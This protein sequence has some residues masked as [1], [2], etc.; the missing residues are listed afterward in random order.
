MK[1][2]LIQIFLVIII[3]LFIPISLAY[4][5][6]YNLA[7]ADFISLDLSFENPDQEN[8]LLDQQNESKVFILSAFSILFPSGINLLKKFPPFFLTMCFSDQKT[9][10]L[11]C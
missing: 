10:V 5:N 2:R 7:K 4:L 8:L 11:R 3:S 6:Y 9:F 1:R